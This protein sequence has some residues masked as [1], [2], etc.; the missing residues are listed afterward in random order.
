VFVVTTLHGESD[1]K[2]YWHNQTPQQRLDAI[3][4]N[5][6]TVY[7]YGD[8]EVSRRLQRVLEIISLADI[9]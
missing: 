6:R 2:V 1:E 3:E 4:L 8:Q 9:K 5:R 7:G